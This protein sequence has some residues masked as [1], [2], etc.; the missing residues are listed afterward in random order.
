LIGARNW[1][2]V[3]QDWDYRNLTFKCCR[4]LN[5]HE[6]IGIL[7]AAPPA[8]VSRIEPS[9]ADY[10]KQNAA[11]V[12]LLAQS[13][14]KVLAERDAI[15]IHEEEVFSQITNEPIVNAPRL[16]RSVFPPIADEQ[17]P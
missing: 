16:R 9:R 8:P 6:I 12:D 3:E 17:T 2:A 10:G 1:R 13:A 11:F 4:N 15:H 7:Q 14:D 5:A